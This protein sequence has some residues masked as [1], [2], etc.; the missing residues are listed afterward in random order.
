[1]AHDRFVYWR[2]ERPTREQLQMV[3]EDY[4]LRLGVVEWETDRFFVTL[5]GKCRHPLTRVT[6]RRAVEA[7]NEGPRERW[8]E[9]YVGEDHID[10]IT[11]LMDQVTEDIA[12]GFAVV[13]ARFWDGKLEG[14]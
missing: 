11:R 13:V 2:K 12:R 7:M 10:V 9:V 3:L 4:V 8:F 5:P 6:D 1:M 14:I